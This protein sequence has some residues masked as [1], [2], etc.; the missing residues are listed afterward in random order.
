MNTR[1]NEHKKQSVF[2]LLQ[3]TFCWLEITKHTPAALRYNQFMSQRTTY[4]LKNYKSSEY[5]PQAAEQVFA[6]LPYTNNPFWPWQHPTPIAFEIV[7]FN[8]MITFQV[9]IPI[10]QDSYVKSQLVAAYPGLTIETANEDYDQLKPVYQGKMIIRNLSLS[11]G[12]YYPLRTYADFSET[13]PLSAVMGTL[14]KLVPGQSAVIQILLATTNDRW[15]NGGY[16]T[17]AGSKDKEGNLIANP[18]KAI[19]EQKLNQTCHRTAI[20]IAT[21]APDST[22]ASAMM[23]NIVGSFAAFANAKYNYFG[24]HTPFMGLDKL[25]HS[26]PH[27]DFN[28]TNKQYLSISEIASL[29]HLPYKGVKDIKNVTWGRTL[30]GEPPDTLPTYDSI[31]ESEKHTVNLFG[32]TEFKNEVKIYGIKDE[33]RRRHMYII[34]KSGTGKSTLLGNMIINDIR[35]GKG[36][37][38]VDPHGDLAEAMLDYIPSN[39][40]NDVIYLNPAD[41]E[42]SVRLNLLEHT[43]HQFKELIASGVI[44]IFKK[45]YEHSWGPRL[46]YIL[47][48]TLLTLVEKDQATME[49]IIKLL[50]NKNFL[51]RTVEKINDPVLKNFWT[52]EWAKM[53]DRQRT[54]AIAPILNKIGQ[55]VTSPLIRNVINSPTSSFSIEE[56]MNEGKILLCNLSQ[57]KLGEDNATLMGAM[58]ITKIQLAAMNRVYIPEAQRRDFVLYVDEFQNFATSSFIKILSEARKYRLSLVLA[59]QYV[60]QIEEDIRYAIFGNCGTLLTFLVGAGDA[61]L[62]SQEFGAQYTPEDLVSIQKHQVVQK[63]MVDGT[64][65]NPFPAWT[66]PPA[67]STNSNREKVIRVSNERYAK[68]KVVYTAEDL[69]D[70]EDDQ[71]KQ[72]K[73][74]NSNHN[75]NKDNKNNQ[76]GNKGKSNN[77][78][79]NQNNNKSQKSEQKQ[80]KHQSKD[81]NQSK[82][83]SQPKP[84]NQ[85]S[86]NETK[87]QKQPQPQPTMPRAEVDQWLTYYQQHPQM[88]SQ[89]QQHHDFVQAQHQ[90]WQRQTE[91]S[92]QIRFKTYNPNHFTTKTLF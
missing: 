64:Q 25:I 29:W 57:G 35:H 40:V 91:S 43:G 24:T 70:D 82:G 52:K 58:L 62:L 49:D 87:S 68:K 9:N 38:V 22:Q 45:L 67:T 31:P 56:A 30:L 92:W 79:T 39:R 11:N 20:T 54:E 76:K 51:D 2:Y 86:S 27:R 18:D 32:K 21:S 47:R 74:S 48:N 55:F 63:L 12:S 6:S 90:L 15:K 61:E 5:G 85:N 17:A 34:G 7:V 1:S 4:I 42:Y 46:E 16:S 36:L 83:Q 59:N 89:Y 19:I 75:K 44:S 66:L 3:V 84:Q 33:D 37:A 78:N 41:P 26:L 28:K 50:T 81:R 10:E 53:Q 71:P 13:D 69:K 77:Q 23:N 80:S 72:K 8:Q 65:S 73:Q 60:E 14:S 88:I